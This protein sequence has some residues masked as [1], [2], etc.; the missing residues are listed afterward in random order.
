MVKSMKSPRRL[1]AVA[2]FAIVAMSAFGFAATNNFTGQ[3]RAGNG[4]DAI[5]GF[6]ISGIG[7]GL[8]DSNPHYLDE[9]H[10]TTN[11]AAS[12]VQVRF[13]DGAVTPTYTNWYACTE[14]GTSVSCDI[15]DDQVEVIDANSLE[16]SA[17]S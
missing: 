5:S 9:V 16:V 17:V 7:Y 14:S 13:S 6:N 3:N 8:Q 4:S 1:A 12:E 11:Q 2:V 15:D 10:F